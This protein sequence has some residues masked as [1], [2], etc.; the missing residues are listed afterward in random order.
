MSEEYTM[1]D[2]KVEDFCES[3]RVEPLFGQRGI[4]AYTLAKESPRH[5]AAVELKATG[6]YTNKEVAEILGFSPVTINYIL[7]QPW[8]E[9]LTVKLIREE[10]ASER[11]AVFRMLDGLA[12]EAI[13]KQ[14]SVLRLP[15]SEKTA[16]PIRKASND[17]L[18]R[19]FGTPVHKTED[20]T[21]NDLSKM[22]DAEI[23]QRLATLRS[24]AQN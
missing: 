21:N 14:A 18:N 9:E 19:V 13:E 24:R 5:R 12:I 22:S 20:V 23:A 8:A 7:R 10:G 6:K 2:L 1:E 3:P 16:E 17:I 11:E 4:P 15:L